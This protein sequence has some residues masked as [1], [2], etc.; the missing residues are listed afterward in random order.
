MTDATQVTEP[1]LS[2]GT[3]SPNPA[4]QTLDLSA[5]VK[6]ADGKEVA[7]SDLVTQQ[8]NLASEIDSFKQY[9]QH[10]SRLVRMD[11]TPQQ[12][13]ES[14]R[15][16]LAKEGMGQDVIEQQVNAY[17]ASLTE[18]QDTPAERGKADQPDPLRE[19]VAAL[20]EELRASKT[21]AIQSELTNVLTQ[22]LDSDPSLSLILKKGQEFGV[23]K[24]QARQTLQ[25]LYKRE[26]LE[27]VK[28][29]ANGQRTF[30]LAWI[31]E[32][33]AAAA[34]ATA[35]IYR[36]VIGSPDALGKVPETVGGDSFV[37][38]GQPKAPVKF[39]R[40]KSVS[41]SEQA[42]DEFNLDAL[43]RAAQKASAG[44]EA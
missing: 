33:S 30:K 37:V 26:L 18:E 25:N 39:D 17:K 4:P 40:K 34:K 32:E 23:N 29:R 38:T 15:Y 12:V 11:G 2:G 10:A 36:S 42:L 22:G 35:D 9:Q 1:T 24:E 19:D 20:R 16:V 28:T 21:E 31:K 5:K 41:E 44:G 8:A 27:R 43:V 14:M 13:E 3:E 7:L 6:L